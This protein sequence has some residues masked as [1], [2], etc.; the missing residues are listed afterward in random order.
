MD[1]L[2]LLAEGL[3]NREIAQRLF[4]SPRTIETH[5]ANL[6]AKTGAASRGDLRALTTR[7]R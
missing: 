5:V 4:V 6:L 7:A 2:T 1:V 3:T